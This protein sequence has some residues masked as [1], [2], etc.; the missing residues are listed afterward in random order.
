MLS[1]RPLT[2]SAEDQRLYV[3]RP[4]DARVERALAEG[5][6]VVLRT[7]RGAG[8]TSLLNRLAGSLDDVVEL[9]AAAAETPEQVLQALA[10]RARLPRR[11]VA[12]IAELWQRSDPLAPP[13]ALRELKAALD[14]AGRRLVVLIDG[15]LDPA[16]AHELF[17]RH[18]DAVF[19]LPATWLVVAYD[20]RAGEYLTPPADVFFE[21][22]DRVDDLDGPTAAEILKRRGLLDELSPEVARFVLAAHDGTPRNLLTLARAKRSLDPAHA[23]AGLRAYAAATAKLPRGAA[24]LLAELQGRGAVAATDPELQ[25]RL[26]V[27]DRQ[28]RRNFALLEEGGLVTQVPAGRAG[29]GRPPTTYLLTELGSAAGM[30]PSATELTADG[31]RA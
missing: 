4:V 25:S 23:E 11:V 14:E 19:A 22:V 6:N 7:S 8:A 9:D 10:A 29:P 15:P 2:S 20:D 21:H 17:G 5:L 27:T 24:M 16:V 30:N 3:R 13:A 18:R 31:G 28:L 26:G 1:A 12:N